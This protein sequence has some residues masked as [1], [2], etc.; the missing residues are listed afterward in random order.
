[1]NY[2]QSIYQD[3]IEGKGY[4]DEKF[5]LIFAIN[6]IEMDLLFPKGGIIRSIK[7]INIRAMARLI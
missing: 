1:M 5:D 3:L 6:A 7:E 4:D 2:P